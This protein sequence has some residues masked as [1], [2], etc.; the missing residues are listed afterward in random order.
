MFNLEIIN[1]ENYMSGCFEKLNELS[2]LC[3]SFKTIPVITK[4]DRSMFD[5]LK[6]YNLIHFFFKAIY[7]EEVRENL[8]NWTGFGLFGNQ[9]GYYATNGD[10]VF[11]FFL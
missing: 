7:D 9:D 11:K 5:E 4:S 8:Q 3:L 1:L 6:I 10:V 2:F